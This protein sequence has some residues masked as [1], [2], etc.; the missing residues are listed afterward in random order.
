MGFN[1]KTSFSATTEWVS[2][3]AA[4][5]IVFFLLVYIFF[6]WCLQQ[7]Y[8]LAK[9][10]YQSRIGRGKDEFSF[11]S[12]VYLNS[13]WPFSF[14]SP[15]IFNN[16]LIIMDGRKICKD[17]SI[18]YCNIASHSVCISC[19]HYFHSNDQFTDWNSFITYHR[20]QISI[21]PFLVTVR[22]WYV[23]NLL[24]FVEKCVKCI[25]DWHT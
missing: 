5:T 9:I 10:K 20:V 18:I 16:Y 8:Y 7:H 11:V 13:V 25:S 2:H 3:L 4:C 23:Q 24:I 22:R 12:T 15:P 1:F 19:A 14:I 17:C 21:L 6:P